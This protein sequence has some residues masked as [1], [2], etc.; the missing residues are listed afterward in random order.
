MTPHE[1]TQ[2][3]LLLHQAGRL[4]EAES[5]YAAALKA[6]PDF[7]PALHL[8]GLLRFQQQDFDAALAAFT[9]AIAAA[10]PNAKGPLFAGRG[11]VFQHLE[12]AGEALADFD[13]AL[14]AGAH[15][16][17]TWNNRGL[18]LNE[19]KHF[20]KALESYA[21]ALAL[22]PQ[23][24]QVHNN[25]GDTLRE[26]RRFDQAL[27]SFERALMLDPA[28]WSTLHNR[29]VAFSQMGRMDD[30][31]GSFDRALA[32]NPDSPA[33]LQA[34]GNLLWSHKTLLGRALAD[35]DRL[36]KIAPDFPFA[37]GSRMRLAMTASR[38]DDYEE[39]K[40]L[41]DDGV[42][43][44]R[45]V[46]EPFIYLALSERPADLQACAR[47]YARAR[48]PAQPP[49]WKK[50]ARRPGRI[51]VGYVCGEFRT[52]ATLYLMAG[53]F[54]AHDRTAF[55]IFA[56]DNGGGDG[57]ALRARFEAA[58]EHVVDIRALSDAE[59]A[60]RIRAED[61]DIL[62]D[63]N[64]YSGQQRL[65][66]FAHRP[67]PIQVSYL[68][69]AGTL[70]APY[71]DY[72]LADRTVIPED[73][74][75]YYDEKIAWLP[76]SYQINDDKRGVGETPARAEAGLPA[77]G[78]VFCNFNH[79]NKF[80][81]ASFSLWMRILAQTPGSV[82]WLLA[83]D[84]LARD[85]LRREAGR[86]S[87]EPA[88]L[89]FAETLPFEKHLARLKLAGL[90]LDGFPYG[91]HTTASDAL[92]AGV[93]LI[94]CRG[95]SFAGR[96]AASLLSALDMPEL[97]TENP[98]DF[99][100]LALRLAREPLLLKGFREKLAQKRVA[101]PLFDTRRNT[102]AI[103]TA[104]QWMFARRDLPPQSFTVPGE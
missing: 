59:A 27:A 79:A 82:L 45:A 87:I 13:R 42:R 53:L 67:A 57:S 8:M 64:G 70:G 83:P 102:S 6:E 28:D 101:A 51:R 69:Y 15:T 18:A 26:L 39:Q 22:S 48:F 3:G 17:A 73:E 55:E 29:A 94:T 24:A 7:H 96:V 84:P 62:V 21:R 89:V 47:L 86:R 32:L 56:F 36:V 16:A 12:R 33:G 41:L 80:T 74:A 30:A 40:A 60:A 65:G 25:R 75:Q 92:W 72:I 9:R 71:M 98:A 88:R 93:P 19:I 5:L 49:L 58:V 85:N 100:A 38:W 95:G 43:A 77:K 46:I 103:E 23:A 99:E 97:V 63:L 78:F 66:V 90:F 104:W 34:R 54:E 2:Q 20:E 35:L 50:Q 68:A 14:A 10:P 81:P 44:D 4:A 37:R 52:H 31:L 1:A 11:E 91:A 76:H 61:I